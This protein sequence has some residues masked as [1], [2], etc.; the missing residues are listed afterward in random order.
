MGGG[1]TWAGGSVSSTEWPP[2]MM[3]EA[4]SRP[5][6]RYSSAD[7]LRD[8]RWNKLRA[9]PGQAHTTPTL[10]APDQH[11]TASC[12]WPADVLLAC[13]LSSQRNAQTYH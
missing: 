13:L 6:P 7:E 3:A 2:L 8:T 12:W 1:L 5:T 4:S 9:R 11:Q 10:L